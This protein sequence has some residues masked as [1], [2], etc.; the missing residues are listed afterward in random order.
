MDIADR[1][2]ALAPDR[3]NAER[4]MARV[5][6]EYAACVDLALSVRDG[7]ALLDNT[8]NLAESVLLARASAAP[9]NALQV[10]LLGRR[11]G[12]EESAEVR[13]AIQLTVAGVA[14][15]LRSTG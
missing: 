6:A 11:R 7:R 1:Y 14:A 3:A 15:A 12:G 8:P 5:R 13:L 2:A 10:E 4:I 9:L